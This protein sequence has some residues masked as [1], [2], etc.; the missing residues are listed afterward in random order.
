M[1][2]PSG[3]GRFM[4]PSVGMGWRHSGQWGDP[5]SRERQQDKHLLIPSVW[6]RMPAAS[7]SLCHLLSSKHSNWAKHGAV[8]GVNRHFF[9]VIFQ[10]APRCVGVVRWGHLQGASLVGLKRCAVNTV[11]RYLHFTSLQCTGNTG[12]YTTFCYKDNWLTN[13]ANGGQLK[14]SLCE[15]LIYV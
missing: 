14:Y 9:Q 6:P 10:I 11:C 12:D 2:L 13:C 15:M 3:C 7:D 5:A 1:F 4:Y 8:C